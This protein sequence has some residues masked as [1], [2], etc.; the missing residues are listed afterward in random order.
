[1]ADEGPACSG[2]PTYAQHSP[3][4]DD[5]F[6][7]LASTESVGDDTAATTFS[8]YARAEA[9]F[10]ADETAR[11]DR[12]AR[13][14][15]YIAWTETQKPHGLPVPPCQTG[16]LSGR[17]APRPAEIEGHTLLR[18]THRPVNGRGWRRHHVR[19]Q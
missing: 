10:T 6:F 15:R 5:G 9:F 4:A 1:M 17:P 14:S 8:F 3:S 19:D 12:T 13:A 11:I 7:R 16:I 2:I 18:E